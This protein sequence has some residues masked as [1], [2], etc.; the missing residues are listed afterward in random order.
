MPDNPD[1]GQIVAALSAAGQTVATAESLTGGLVA[2]ALTDVPGV[3]SVFRG[4]VV[5]YQVEQKVRLAGVPAELLTAYGP[6]SAQVATAL[7]VGVRDLTGADWGLATTGVAGPEPHDGQPPGVVWIG[8]ARPGSAPVSVR[9]QFEGDRAAI[10]RASV[11]AALQLLA[12]TV[13]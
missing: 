13:R 4:G 9:H 6:V 5:A 11:A 3:S 12:N 8:L 2:A 1:P 7:A 10:R